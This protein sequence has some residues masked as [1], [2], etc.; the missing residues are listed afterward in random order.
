M[1]CKGLYWYM[2][3]GGCGQWGC[4]YVLAY[5]RSFLFLQGVYAL[6]SLV[7]VVW[8]VIRVDSPI[9]QDTGG[10]YHIIGFLRL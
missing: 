10:A 7:Q 1:I 8:W 6:I 4:L 5:I 2:R 9:G 3:R